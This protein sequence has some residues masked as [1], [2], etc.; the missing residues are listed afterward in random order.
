MSNLRLPKFTK[1][2]NLLEELTADKL[3]AICEAVNSLQLTNGRNTKARLTADG[4]TLDVDIEG[5]EGSTDRVYNWQ[6]V[7]ETTVG[8]TLTI[9]FHPGT[10]NRIMPSNMLDFLECDTDGL[11]YLKL[12]AETNG[13]AITS[14]ELVLDEDEIDINSPVQNAAPS[15]LEIPVGVVFDGVYI[16]IE[17]DNLQY[18]PKVTF[19]TSDSPASPGDEPFVRWWSWQRVS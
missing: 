14:V 6:S 1:G 9:K 17:F 19:V 2:G 4:Q 3:N 5:G 12:V 8:D 7:S 10:L 11:F 16:Q 15:T 13:K 18:D